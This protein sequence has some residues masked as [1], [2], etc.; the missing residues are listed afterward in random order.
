MTEPVQLTISGDVF[1]RHADMRVAGFTVAG[2]D[3]AELPVLPL[4][5]VLAG[6]ELRA[7]TLERL[8][9]HP[10]I[11]PWRRATQLAGLKPSTYRGSPE[12]LARR[13]LRGFTITTPIPMVDLYCAVSA[14][15]LSPLG[16]YDPCRL[17]DGVT[18]DVRFA[19]ASDHFVPLGAS[20]PFPDANVVVYA[21]GSTTLCWNYNHRDSAETCLKPGSPAAVV[22]GESVDASQYPALDRALEEFAG[23]LIAAGAVVS[24]TQVADAAGP[25]LTL[26]WPS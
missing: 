12:A 6:P 17:A 10:L 22:L 18:I 5:H 13:Y 8:T 14:R 4:E 24:P 20:D 11:G 23:L 25:T 2:L 1:D 9:E 16:A 26:T 3:R 7:A 21:Q 19:Q 15:H